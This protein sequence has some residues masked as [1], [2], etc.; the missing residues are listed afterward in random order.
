[1]TTAR[2]RWTSTRSAA[3]RSTRPSRCSVDDYSTNRTTGSFIVIDPQ[4]NATAGAGVIRVLATTHASPE[5]GAPPGPP[6]PRR[7]LRALWTLRGRRCCSPGCRGRASRPSPPASRRP[8]CRAG[9]P[10]SCSTATTCG[11][12]STATSASRTRTARRTCAAPARWRACS[13][14]PARSRLIALICPFEEDRRLIRMLHDDVGL[15]FLEVFVDHVARGVRAARPEGPLRPGPGGPAARL[16]RD[17]LGLR[18]ADRRRPRAF[19]QLGVAFP[20]RSPACWS[21]SSARSA[22]GSRR[23]GGPEEP[24]PTAARAEQA[25]PRPA[26]PERA[27]GRGR[28]PAGTAA[29][30]GWRGWRSACYRGRGRHRDAAAGAARVVEPVAHLRHEEGSSGTS[31]TSSSSANSALSSHT[32]LKLPRRRRWSSTACPPGSPTTCAIC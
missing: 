6:D 7:P 15:P 4:T 17:R 22:N 21:C 2:R 31:S 19:A 12:A 20:S 24:S 1:M 25:G 13:P 3:C 11:T 18:D 9:A 16:H 27:A 28:E 32:V 26:R 23:T 29:A 14:S 30:G 10:P 8:T 5:R